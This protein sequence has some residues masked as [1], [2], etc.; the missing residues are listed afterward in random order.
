MIT[1]K[2]WKINR[3]VFFLAL[4]AML[5]ALSPEL[6]AQ[7]FLGAVMGGM[8]ISQVDGDE[9]YGYHRVGGHMGVAAILPINKW[10]ITLETVFNQK[11]AYQK[12]TY[13]DSVRMFNGKYDLRLN[14]IEVPLM[15]H[16]TDRNIIT[17][18]AGFSWGRLVSSKEIEHGGWQP[19]YSDTIPFN[20][21]DF[22][23]LVDVQL[24]VYKRLKFNVRFAYSL[25]PIR[26]RTFTDPYVIDSEPWTRKQYNHMFTFRLVYVFNEIVPRKNK[27]ENGDL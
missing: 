22:N 8:N 26:E 19:P 25:A 24:R 11:G 27:D 9:V 18:G 10:D 21:N 15:A 4:S 3:I 5:S 23:V 2:T 14:Y 20:K 12:Q 17:A 13:V 7:R 6:H 16:Y 1:L